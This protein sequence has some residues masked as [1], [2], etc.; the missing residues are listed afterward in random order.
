MAINNNASRLGTGFTNVQKVIGANTN[1]RLGSAI[2][3]G[4]NSEAQGV[5]SDLGKQQNDFQSG[6]QANSLDNDQNKQIRENILG[7]AKTLGQGESLSDQDASQFDKFRSG[8]YQGPTGLQNTDALAAKADETSQLAR[9]T[10]TAGG[11]QALLQ[12]YAGGGRQYTQGQQ[13]LDN[14]ILGQTGGQQLAQVRRAGTGLA[15]DVNQASNAAQQQAQLAQ[16]RNQQFGQQTGQEAQQAVTGLQG[17]LQTTRDAAAAKQANLLQQAQQLGKGPV[18]AD[19]LAQ[20]GLS[21]DTKVFDM[22]PEQIQQYVNAG[23]QGS[24]INLSSVANQSQY[25]QAQALQRLAGIQDPTQGIGLQQNQVGSLKEVGLDNAGFSQAAK[26][27]E[28]AL[29]KAYSDT[30]MSGNETYNAGLEASGELLKRQLAQ[31]AAT[32]PDAKKDLDRVNEILGSGNYNQLVNEGFLRANQSRIGVGGTSG[33]TYGTA[34]GVLESPTSALQ[35]LLS[36]NYSSDK[37]GGFNPTEQFKGLS[38]EDQQSIAK[39]ALQQLQ[40]SAAQRKQQLGLNNTIGSEGQGNI[41]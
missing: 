34:G 7:Q 29:N 12:R 2:Q 37:Y 27:R 39:Q 8:Q 18:S 30:G 13:Q 40:A 25:A 22:T 14:L 10:Q 41:S 31:S 3:G 20:L 21:A 16:S 36:G 38:A 15:Q 9:N 28:E 33:A 19:L 5:K 35:N 24:D 1:N 17:Q 26:N 32:S 6:L 4:I 23:T 11:R